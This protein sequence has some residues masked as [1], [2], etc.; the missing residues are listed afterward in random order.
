MDTFRKIAKRHSH[1]VLKLLQLRFWCWFRIW[2][3]VWLSDKY[4]SDK[5]LNVWRKKVAIRQFDRGDSWLSNVGNRAMRE[6]GFNKWWKEHSELKK[7][8]PKGLARKKAN[9]SKDVGL[10]N[11]L[12]TEIGCI[13][14]DFAMISDMIYSCDEE[15]S[16]RRSLPEQNG[17]GQI[18]KLSCTDGRKLAET[19]RCIVSTIQSWHLTLMILLSVVNVSII[20]KWSQERFFRSTWSTLRNDGSNGQFF[21]HV[22]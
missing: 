7:S 14:H 16:T 4:D 15:W 3:Q 21:S 10:M 1:G 11:R 22:S 13:F 6:F 9:N 2:Y 5:C 8:N 18:R 20:K 17:Q 19:A 12:Q